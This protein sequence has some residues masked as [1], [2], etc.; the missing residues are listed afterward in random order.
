MC[1]LGIWQISCPY[2]GIQEILAIGALTLKMVEDGVNILTCIETERENEKDR[3]ADRGNFTDT[4][5][6]RGG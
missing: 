4:Q 6:E 3:L 2:L 5:R 1:Y